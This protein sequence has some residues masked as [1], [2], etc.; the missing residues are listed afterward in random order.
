MRGAQ[1]RFDHLRIALN[2]LRPTLGDLAAVVEHHDPVADAHHQAH[3]VLDQEHRDTAASDGGDQLS[4]RDALGRVHPC[5]GF[6]QGEQPGLGGKR[7]RD[8]ETALVAVGQAAR[9]GVGARTDADIVEELERAPFYGALL[10]QGRAVAQDRSDHTAPGAHVA[11]DHHVFERR[12][13]GE[14]ADV[15]E[16][17]RNPGCG[18]AVGREPGDVSAGEG[19]PSVVRRVDT[20]EDVEERGLSRAIGADEAEHLARRDAE[21][22]LLQRLHAAEALADARRFEERAHSGCPAGAS[23]RSA[24]SRCL[25]AEGSRPAGRNSMTSTSARPKSSIR[26]TSGSTSMRPKSA[27]CAGSTV[28]RRISGTNESSS[29]PRITPQ[30]FPMPPRTTMATTMIDSTSTKLSGE[31]KPWIAENMPPA[32]PPKLAPMAKASSFM[33]RVFMPID[34]AAISSSRIASQA[35]PTR[36]FCRRRLTTMMKSTTASSRK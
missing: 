25:T 16:R 12:K 31:M 19:K 24:S 4:E 14:Q 27:C 18:D 1:I 11:P 2:L 8:L 10:F 13:V 28:Q 26:I 32:T 29:A 34:R 6:V 33:L 21:G 5:G 17:A 22:N 20:G 23:L 3:V 35:R 36:E 9:R 7:S 30:T 15:L